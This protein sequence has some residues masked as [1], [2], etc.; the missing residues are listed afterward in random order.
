MCQPI[1]NIYEKLRKEY[2]TLP[3]FESYDEKLHFAL[4]LRDPE[5]MPS[6]P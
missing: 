5:L 2:E 1:L 4:T 6:W 3:Q